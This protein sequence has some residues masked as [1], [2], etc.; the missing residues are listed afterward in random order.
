MEAKTLQAALSKLE[1]ISVDA[2]LKT[3]GADWSASGGYTKT[4]TDSTSETLTKTQ[5]SEIVANGNADGIDH[6]QDQFILLLN[7]VVYVQEQQPTKVVWNLGYTGPSAIVYTVYV[8]WLKNPSSMPANVAAQ[9]QQLGFTNSDYQTILAQDPFA[10]GPAN[11]D[12]SRYA[13]TTWTFPYE[14]PLQASDCNQGVCTCTSFSEVIKNDLQ[15]DDTSSYEN[16]YSISLSKRLG[17]TDLIGLKATASFTLTNGAATTN[18]RGSTQSATA[19]VVCPSLNY[20]GPTLMQ[21]YWD[22]LYGSFLFAPF[23]LS[24]AVVMQKGR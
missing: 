21:V 5:T 12:L 19:T 14:P 4:Q 15:N 17:L 9:L 23:E 13:P 7:P 11:I 10:N 22:T 18:T 6:G 20:H 16:Q 8:S 2:K 3:G 1:S 24:N